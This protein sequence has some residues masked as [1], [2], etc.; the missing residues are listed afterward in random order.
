MLKLKVEH[1]KLLH[2]PLL[3]TCIQC[4]F[5][6]ARIHNSLRMFHIVWAPST[7]QLSLSY[8]ILNWNIVVQ[9]LCVFAF[10]ILFL[11]VCLYFS[12]FLFSLEDDKLVLFMRREQWRGF[13]HFRENKFSTIIQFSIDSCNL[14]S[15]RHFQ[16]VC[17][18][19]QASQQLTNKR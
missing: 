15:P 4:W 2:E 9:K 13:F 16:T 10:R 5:G 18:C 3:R 11:R 19:F 6:N 17:V 12:L 7:L 14:I 8:F 1:S